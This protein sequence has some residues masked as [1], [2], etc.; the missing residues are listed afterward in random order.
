MAKTRVVDSAWN[1]R[2]AA[3]V[4]AVVA[5]VSVVLWHGLDLWNEAW[6]YKMPDLLFLPLFFGIL[7]IYPILALVAFY[8]RL[9]TARLA[10]LYALGFGVGWFLTLEISQAAEFG[11]WKG[12]RPEERTVLKWLTSRLL[13][14]VTIV[15]TC[16]V[17]SMVVWGLCR[18]FRGKLLVQ[19]GTLCSKC[20]Y[21]LIGN[22][23]GTCPE[24]G[25]PTQTETARSEAG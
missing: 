16:V 13:Y 20:G 12:F 23:S 5:A 21:S 6:D 7:L 4:G 14:F 25:R 10:L 22:V 24:C 9:P 18:P 17:L 1:K 19:D 8:P 11:L 3:L 2:M 15:P